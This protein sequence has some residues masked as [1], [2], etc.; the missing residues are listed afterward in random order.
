MIFKRRIT[1]LLMLLFGAFV[2]NVSSDD[3]KF[4]HDDF[5]VSSRLETLKFGRDN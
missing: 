2:V 4:D 1:T 5:Q 3:F